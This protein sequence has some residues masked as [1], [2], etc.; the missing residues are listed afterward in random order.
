MPSFKRPFD[1]ESSL[2]IPDAKAPCLTK[3]P[4]KTQKTVTP[5]FRQQAT[6]PSQPQ[7]PSLF[8]ASLQTSQPPNSSLSE[9]NTK[10]PTTHTTTQPNFLPLIVHTKLYLMMCNLCA[11]II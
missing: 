9:N 6:T 7:H 2:N 10:E 1:F 8:A 5:T 3:D 4:T 11:Q